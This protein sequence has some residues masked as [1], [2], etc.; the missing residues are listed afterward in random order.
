MGLLEWLNGGP[1][2]GA[3]ERDHLGL[4]MAKSYIIC[5]WEMISKASLRVGDRGFEVV[6]AA[7]PNQ[8]WKVPF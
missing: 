3:R 4:R 2:L 1:R 5:C 7:E 6:E 8:P